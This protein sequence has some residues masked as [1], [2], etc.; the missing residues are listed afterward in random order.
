MVTEI[1][2]PVWSTNMVGSNSTAINATPSLDNYYDFYSLV[3]EQVADDDSTYITIP[4][5]SFHNLAL[6]FESE[7]LSNRYLEISKIVFTFRTRASTEN[8][9]NKVGIGFINESPTI[10]TLNDLAC[11]I[12]GDSLYT[13]STISTDWETLS[14]SYNGS[15][16]IPNITASLAYSASDPPLVLLLGAVQPSDSTKDSSFS[17]DITQAYVE[18][19]YGDGTTETS[20]MIY[21]KENGSWISV[22]CTIYQKQNGSWIEA[23]SSVFED[24]NNYTFQE[25]T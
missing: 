6:M 25:V 24:G 15:L 16:V 21:L 17:I 9:C 12:D 22:P 1:L 18:V 2:R 20:E 23:D 14:V 5:N 8:I 7:N 3:D 13:T 19:T 10:S 4:A 11:S